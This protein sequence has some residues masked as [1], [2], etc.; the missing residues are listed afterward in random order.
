MQPR[1]Y[2]FDD[3]SELR[4]LCAMLERDA[5]RNLSSVKEQDPLVKYLLSFAEFLEDRTK[6]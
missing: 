6:D 3:P 1:W 2:G 5:G 4:A